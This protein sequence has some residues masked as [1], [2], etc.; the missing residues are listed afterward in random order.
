MAAKVK[1]PDCPAGAPAW[2]ATFADLMSLLMVFFVLL[3]S[4]SEM[5]AQ[6]FKKAA[7]SLR[8]AFGVQREK[9]TE[10]IP[11]GTSIVAEEYSPGEPTVLDFTLP[12]F[13]TSDTYALERRRLLMLQED[14][15]DIASDNLAKLQK[16]LAEDIQSGALQ[17][18]KKDYDVVLTFP[19]Q[20]LFVSGDARIAPEAAQKLSRL[21]GALLE[22]R[23]LI[24]VDAY[25][26]GNQD[27]TF[28]RN[29]W[30]ISSAQA[31]SL[32]ALLQKA[33]ALPSQRFLM[34]SFGDAKPLAADN[35][36]PLDT[37]IE[38]SIQLSPEIMQ[39]LKL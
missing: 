2:L 28:F 3:L 13:M 32:T 20:Q 30:D 18:E 7:G 15:K 27:S 16:S 23:G 35:V 1:C 9:V 38:L 12:P 6:K 4:F 24:A 33:T 26:A 14:M 25:S 22:I 39:D 37:R 34:R 8:L 5:D 29:A 19:V 10:Q 11:L 36:S 17:I 21:A 31:S